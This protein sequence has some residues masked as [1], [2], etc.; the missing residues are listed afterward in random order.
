M[1]TETLRAAQQSPCRSYA[2]PE[3]NVKFP[4]VERM[5]ASAVVLY[6]RRATR[7]SGPSLRGCPSRVTARLRDLLGSGAWTRGGCSSRLITRLREASS[8]IQLCSRSATYRCL[9][10]AIVVAVSRQ[11]PPSR[12]CSVS[13]RAVQLFTN[14]R[15]R[16]PEN[17]GRAERVARRRCAGDT[18]PI[19]V[20]PR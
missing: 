17:D 4:K 14:M 13:R 15:A 1:V 6:R 5:L 9:I 7:S 8:W 10:H 18:G 19:R 20:R 11:R 16:L 2:H 12:V 3:L